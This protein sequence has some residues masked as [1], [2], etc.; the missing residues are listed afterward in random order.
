[1]ATPPL[2]RLKAGLRRADVRCADDYDEEEYG[3]AVAGV[4]D[5]ACAIVGRCGGGGAGWAFPWGMRVRLAEVLLRWVAGAGIL[6]LTR[7]SCR[8][9]WDTCSHAAV[10]QQAVVSVFPCS[11]FLHACLRG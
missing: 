2:C 5:C 1:M 4:A 3:A 6:H 11:T 7:G 8:G 10:H 9:C